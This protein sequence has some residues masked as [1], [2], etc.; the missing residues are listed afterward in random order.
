VEGTAAEEAGR[1][2]R[3]GSAAG[4]WR[5]TRTVTGDGTEGNGSLRVMIGCLR[6]GDLALFRTLE[7]G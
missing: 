1:Q 3:T 2:E 5:T 4:K 7:V 6:G